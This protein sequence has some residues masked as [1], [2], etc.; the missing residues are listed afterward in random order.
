VAL[1][2]PHTFSGAFDETTENTDKENIAP[3]VRRC[4]P[5]LTIIV[6]VPE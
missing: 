1:L 3:R 5:V 2:D 6:K 4:L